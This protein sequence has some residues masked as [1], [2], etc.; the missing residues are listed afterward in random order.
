MNIKELREHNRQLSY[1]KFLVNATAHHGSVYDYSLVK[2]KNAHTKITIICP[3]H[4]EFQ[5]VPTSHLNCMIACQGCAYEQRQK[6]VRDKQSVIFF[7]KLNQLKHSEY[8]YSLV[9]YHN[10]STPIKIIC[11]IHGIFEQLP[12]VHLNGHKCPQCGFDK[13][14]M[15]TYTKQVFK[16]NPDLKMSNGLIYYIKFTC[17]ETST[18]FYKIGITKYTIEHR[19]HKWYHTKYIIEVIDVYNTT[20]YNAFIIEQHIKVKHKQ[21]R[22]RVL[23]KKFMGRTECFD[24]DILNGI[25]LE[26]ISHGL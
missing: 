14:K 12:H 24:C 1:D 17:R 3:I 11:H 4:G 2:Y 26:E 15:F 5:Q 25:K 23:E 19:F 10:T 8:D 16:E 20:I 21:N 9:T 13:T 18:V 22:Y 7:D 6:T